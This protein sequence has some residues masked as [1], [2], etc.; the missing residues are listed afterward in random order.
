MPDEAPVLLAIYEQ[1]RVMA[2]KPQSLKTASG[3]SLK[4]AKKPETADLKQARVNVTT[5]A[6]CRS[7]LL[8]AIKAVGLSTQ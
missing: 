2:P 1:I 5:L 3:L 4:A 7:L 8:L 6:F